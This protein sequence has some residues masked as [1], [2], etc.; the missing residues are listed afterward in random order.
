[1]HACEHTKIMDPIRNM[2]KNTFALLKYA[3]DT[4]VDNYPEYFND[5][6]NFIDDCEPINGQVIYQQLNYKEK[7]KKLNGF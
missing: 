2:L 4:S 7:N 3:A 5:D 6:Y 1:M